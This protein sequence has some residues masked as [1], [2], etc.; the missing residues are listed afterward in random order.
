MFYL[1]I[2]IVIVVVVSIFRVVVGFYRADR[3]RSTYKEHEA[4][5]VYNAVK[6]HKEE[7]IV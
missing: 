4:A 5:L 2:F 6:R 7:R 3:I 1:F